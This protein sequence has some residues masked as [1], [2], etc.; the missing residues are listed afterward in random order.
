[1]SK[2]SDIT[3]TTRSATKKEVA[4]KKQTA[5]LSENKDSPKEAKW[6]RLGLV[7]TDV[8]GVFYNRVGTHV[9]ENGVSMSFNALQH[10][11][12]VR[13]EEVIGELADTPAKMLKV[14]ALDPRNPL[15]IRVDAAK[16]AA[17]YYDKKQPVGVEA[18]IKGSLVLSKETVLAALSSKDLSILENLLKKVSKSVAEE[19]Q[20]STEAESED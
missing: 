4:G 8:P 6:V 10:A 13:D 16:A 3:V 12:R 17:P 9:D 2:H 14:V 5:I 18:S 15:D 7:P 11:S 19:L 1:M 20:I